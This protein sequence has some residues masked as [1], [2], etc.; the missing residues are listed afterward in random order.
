MTLESEE[1]KHID[2]NVNI[3]T[4]SKIKGITSWL[5]PSLNSLPVLL[6]DNF[7]KS[8]GQIVSIHEFSGALNNDCPSFRVFILVVDVRPE[9]VEF[10]I[11]I[12]SR[13]WVRAIAIIVRIALSARPFW[14]WLP[15]PEWR[16][17]CPLEDRWDLNVVEV[18]AEPL[19]EIYSPTMIP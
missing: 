4:H 3:N 9:V 17:D 10:D 5:S 18:N 13:S 14:W 11:E 2:I 8:F 1:N 6:K 19:S 16:R 7:Y 15:A 12:L